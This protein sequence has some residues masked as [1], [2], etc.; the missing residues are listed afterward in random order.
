MPATAPSNH[1]RLPPEIML[2]VFKHLERTASP[3]TLATAARTSHSFHQDLIPVLYRSPTLI[4]DNCRSFFHGLFSTQCLSQEEKDAWWEGELGDKKSRVARRI[5][6][7]GLVQNVFLAD[8]QAVRICKAAVAALR[9]KGLEA[10]PND[11]YTPHMDDSYPRILLF[12]GRVPLNVHLSSKLFLSLAGES[13]RLTPTLIPDALGGMVRP[14]GILSVQLP[15]E[16]CNKMPYLWRTV[17]TPICLEVDP[18]MLV[19]DDVGK[20]AHVTSPPFC[21][22]GVAIRF[23]ND[24]GEPEIWQVL[25]SFYRKYLHSIT[26]NSLHCIIYNY[27]PK[28]LAE[29]KRQDTVENAIL[30]K[31][32]SKLHQSYAPREVKLRVYMEGAVKSNVSMEEMGNELREFMK[33]A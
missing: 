21:P 6:M 19:I 28:G 1:P 2:M 29:L 22:P 17:V 14:S 30:S 16:E 15:R 31:A 26:Q 32:F 12:Y 11:W 3:S 8:L 13:E 25:E 4:K 24:V 20:G 5:A 7:L 33:S 18:R 27:P 23:G 10:P 9:A